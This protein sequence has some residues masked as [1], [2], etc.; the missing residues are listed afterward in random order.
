[1][2]YEYILYIYIHTYMHAHAHKA[3]P[4]KNNEQLMQKFHSHVQCQIIPNSQH[5]EIAQ[6]FVDR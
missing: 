4:R 6:P 1:M 2:Y 5:K 3:H